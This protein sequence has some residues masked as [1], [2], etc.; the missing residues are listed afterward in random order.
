[1]KLFNRWSFGLGV[2]KEYLLDRAHLSS[3]H[4]VE[5]EWNPDVGELC[6]QEEVD[7]I[8]LPHLVAAF[9]PFGF[10]VEVRQ[11]QRLPIRIL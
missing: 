10:A 7:T 6:L 4:R 8:G 11:C 2:R 3:N 9:I 5:T 1:M